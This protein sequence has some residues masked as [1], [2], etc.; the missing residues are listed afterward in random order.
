MRRF[1]G[2]FFLFL[3]FGLAAC[4]AKEAPTTENAVTAAP[5]AENAAVAA[6][7]NAKK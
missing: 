4:A 6:P 2:M 1:T 3:L 5:A 7:D